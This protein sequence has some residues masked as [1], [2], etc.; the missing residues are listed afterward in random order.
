MRKIFLLVLCLSI[1]PAAMA[2]ITELNY[3]AQTD[4]EVTAPSRIE[5][6]FNTGLM[7]LVISTSIVDI[8]D[9]VTT[10]LFGITMQGVSQGIADFL[11]VSTYNM[12]EISSNGLVPST[13]IFD[14]RAKEQ[15]ELSMATPWML[16]IEFSGYNAGFSTIPMTVDML[17][18]VIVYDS[19][20]NPY[21]EFGRTYDDEST[22]MPISLLEND[23]DTFDPG[24]Y[25]LTLEI[26][27]NNTFD[28]EGT[29]LFGVWATQGGISA[30][31]TE[32]THIPIPA[33]GAILLSSIGFGLVGWLRRRR[34][35]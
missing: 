13:A 32:I 28:L 6:D 17:M 16:D 3:E 12:A 30:E 11:S 31:I 5:S 24:T 20:M 19:A 2:V 14:S 7:P 10:T 1:S 35:L 29:P 9:P 34:T 33:P 15:F 8:T 4:I 18:N 27:T 25:Y 26:S 21:S 23:G 22:P